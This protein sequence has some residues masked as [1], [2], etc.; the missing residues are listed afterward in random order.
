M[1]TNEVAAEE[2]MDNTLAQSHKERKKVPKDGACM[3]C[4]QEHFDSL[5]LPLLATRSPINLHI[6]N[7]YFILSV[8]MCC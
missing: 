4:L 2:K 8:Q 6:F 1:S 5:Y 7:P 3:V